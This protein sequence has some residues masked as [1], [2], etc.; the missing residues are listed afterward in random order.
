MK[1]ALLPLLIAILASPAHAAPLVCLMQP[2]RIAELGTSSPGVIESLTV[3]RGDSVRRGQV[4]ALLRSDVERAVLG[5]AQSK[6]QAD[7]DVRAAQAAADFARQKFARSEDLFK[8]QFISEQALDQVR[9]ETQLA[10]QKLAQAREQRGI[11]DRERDLARSQLAQRTLVSPFDGVVAERHVALGERVEDRAVMRIVALNPLHVEAMAPA[12][13]FGTLRPGMTAQ[14]QPDL[15][16]AA[17]VTAT[18][19]QVDRLIDGATNTFRIRLVLPNPNASLPAGARCKLSFAGDA[20]SQPPL[21]IEPPAR[22]GAVAPRAQPVAAPV[23]APALASGQASVLAALES[24]RAAWEKRETSAYLAAYAPD[25]AGKQRAS[26]ERERRERLAAT[27]PLRIAV[28][29]AR[30]EHRP[31]GVRVKFRQTYDSPRYRDV[32]EKS[33][34]F[35]QRQGH[36]LIADDRSLP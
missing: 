5:V 16:G 24:W 29:H 21:S 9:T 34:L 14:V 17:P 23:P 3:D 30:T 6:A 32:V 18:I 12:A 2:S 35:V 20:P 10:V 26:W 31:E 15:P 33:L 22:T 4:V 11:W 8:K 1:S 36:S 19:K 7:A 28:S 25:F 27:G 13:R